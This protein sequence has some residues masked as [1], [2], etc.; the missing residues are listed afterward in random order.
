MSGPPDFPKAYDPGPPEARWYQE[1]EQAGA[2]RPEINPD[3]EPFCI[4]IPPPNVTG[5]LHMGH[6][7]EHAL[8]DATIRHKRMQGYAT[9]WLPGTDHA[10]IATQNVVERELAKEGVDRHQLGR[11][12]FLERVW[13]WKEQSGGQITEQMRRMGS[14]CDWT[15]E[16]F[17]MDEGLSRAVR[18]VFVGLFEDDLVYRA[19]RIINWCPRCHTALS[20]IEVE[21]EDVEGEL[22]YFRYPLA[23]G[24]GGVTVATTRAETMLGDT[25]VAVNPADDRYRDLVGKTLRHPFSD[26]EMPI[27]ADDVVDPEFG[28][29]AVKVTPA[30]DPNDFD[31][32]QRHGLPAI[33]IFDESAF[34]TE[35]GG[36]RFVG[37]DRFS[38]RVSVKEALED[39][40][41]LEKVETHHHAVGHCYRCHTVV[42]PRLSLQWFV[43]VQPL[44]VP[45][46][47]AV[48]GDRT[49]FIPKRWDKLY[50][51]WMENLRDWCI[52]RQIWWGH[53]IPAWYCPDGHVTVAMDDAV[54]CTQ[55]GSGEIVQD[56]DVLDTWFSSALWP[57]TTLGWPDETD[58]LRR[59]YPNTVLHTGFDI[60]TFWVARMMQMGLQFAG[61]VPFHEVAI[62]GLV[63]D[64]DGRKMSKSF[65]NV[66]DPLELADRYG[67]DALRFALT[68][69]ASPGQDVPLAEEWV[70]GA[71]NFLNKL[72]N[73]ARF[74]S[75]SLDGRTVAEI[76]TTELPADLALADQWILSRLGWV[77]DTVDSGFA[78]YDFADALRE[79][80][81]FTWGEF[82]DWYIELAKLPLA[83]DGPER[84]RTQ[85]VLGRVLSSVVRL[86]HPVVPFATEELWHRLGGDGLCA[87]A[88]WPR[89]KAYRPAPDAEAA[90]EAVIEVV[91]AIRRFRSEHTI[92]PSRKFT[93][94]VVPADEGQQATLKSVE[95]EI[96][97]LAGLDAVVFEA[98]RPPRENEQRM[99]AAGAEV[100]VP[101]EGLIDLAAATGQLDRQIKKLTADLE[102]TR[103]KLANDGF[104]AKAPAEVIE[105]ERR[106]EAETAEALEALRAQRALLA[107][108]EPK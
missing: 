43:R 9:L 49:R 52:S 38:A 14:S 1:W 56:E 29:G 101:F 4:V 75:Q 90:M 70:E 62:H 26:R 40:R 81:A 67:A 68:R 42:E 88:P 2:F 93:A 3:G 98:G 55:C 37:Q 44:T 86:L 97:T 20:D 15:R 36:E 92:P 54:A 21:H 47:D 18:L 45:A 32:A 66:I 64:A 30:H 19:N 27:V 57:F 51:D 84:D 10:G 94:Y 58:D 5:S 16:R 87:L 78:G 99:V 23:D 69:A 60:I 33:D 46:I 83:S 34:I 103:Q 95:Q 6:A 59:F 17:T 102:R 7:F 28:T 71:R 91:S 80:Y 76:D 89:A 105:K 12:S 39:E 77:I 11:Q 82:C 104:V 106:R 63:R 53:R 107:T 96:T 8:I 22:C 35:A 85:L 100:V 72:W 108:G 24:S 48:R 73:S 61:D 50:F 25:A 79:L 74:V 31:I 65:G 13:S 41:L